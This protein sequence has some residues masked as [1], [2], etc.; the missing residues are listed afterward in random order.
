MSDGPWEH[1]QPIAVAAQRRLRDDLDTPQ[2]DQT[3]VCFMAK[4]HL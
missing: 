1:D 2:K 4:R 3:E